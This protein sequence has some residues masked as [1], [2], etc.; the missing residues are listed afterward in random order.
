MLRNELLARNVYIDLG[1]LFLT[2]LWYRMT[3]VFIIVAIIAVGTGLG[4]YTYSLDYFGDEVWTLTGEYFSPPR[5]MAFADES[6]ITS[7]SS[8]EGTVQIGA[9]IP[10]TGD[11]SNDG[12]D[13]QITVDLAESHFNDYLEKNGADWRLEILTEDTATNPEVAL[14]KISDLSTMGVNAIVGTYSSGELQNVMEFAESNDM[15]LISYASGAESLAIAGDNIFRFVPS[16]PYESLAITKYLNDIG[17]TTL[18]PIWRDDA[19]GEG[20]I[21]ALESE[22]SDVGGVVDAGVRYHSGITEFST[23][24]AMLA[25][26]VDARIAESG[27][28]RVAVAALAFGEIAGI[29]KSASHHESLSKVL[30]YGTDAIVNNDDFSSDPEIQGLIDEAGLIVPIFVLA[31]NPVYDEVV[32]QATEISGRAPVI[33]A[34]P[35]YDAVWVI[36]LSMLKADSSETDAIVSEMPGVLEDYSGALGKIILNDAGDLDTAAF[37]IYYVNSTQWT[38]V[39]LYDSESDLFIHEGDV[40]VDVVPGTQI[41]K[42]D[43]GESGGCLIA[44][45]AY[46]SELA[47]QVQL[48][49]E[50]R[51]NTLLSTASGTSF[52]TGF[53]S[54]Y[55]SFSPAIADLERENGMFKD[56]VRMA[57]TP[58]LY[59]MGVMTLADPDSEVSVIAF[60][61]ATMAALAGI[62]LA[63]PIFTARAA[64]KCAKNLV[65]A[66]KTART[67][68][69]TSPRNM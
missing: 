5:V 33:Y 2:S 9:L 36:G 22:I 4:A 17:V 67:R 66:S 64:I 34:I 32:S 55:Y 39:G 7:E 69:T 8:L 10:V 41:P 6:E 51:D 53:N 40:P 20:M 37:E 30:W 52:M 21:Q 60:G 48:L 50:I 47:P 15:I 12:A 31:P 44:T 18:V 23:E 43:A 3:R 63:G 28:D 62:Y 56:V 49:R 38:R 26:L 19:W 25:D 14:D 65:R 24:T 16:G 11:G 58:A 45:A 29:M 57:I 61:L 59:V 13:I 35:A 54:F 46:G 1:L 42:D 27:S 68:K